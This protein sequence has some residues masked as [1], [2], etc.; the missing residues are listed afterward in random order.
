[1]R[2]ASIFSRFFTFNFRN[3]F[4]PLSICV[5]SSK[6][7]SCFHW[8]KKANFVLSFKFFKAKTHKVKW[9][10]R[11]L[12]STRFSFW[13]SPSFEFNWRCVRVWMTEKMLNGE[14]VRVSIKY[15]PIKNG[16]WVE[17][18]AL[19]SNFSSFVM[20]FTRTSKKRNFRLCFGRHCDCHNSVLF[21]R[22]FES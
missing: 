11:I 14:H 5:A 17:P 4:V 15:F 16:Q 21:R 3:I 19:A 2:S 9:N 6:R 10:E 18:L 12:L 7:S 22:Q 1:M 8:A 13:I 20:H